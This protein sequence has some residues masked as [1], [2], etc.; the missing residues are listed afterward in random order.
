MERMGEI[1]AVRGD[2]LEITFCRPADCGKCHAC[3]GQMANTVVRLKGQ[4]NIGDNAIVDM[5]TSTVMQASLIAYALPLAGLLLGAVVGNIF[6]DLAT[7]IGGLIGL[8]ITLTIVALTEKKRRT[9]P[10]WQMQLLEIIPKN[11]IFRKVDET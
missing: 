7:V 5:P 9:Q 11:D 6:G 8:A 3:S 4:G 10:K 2:E 1:T